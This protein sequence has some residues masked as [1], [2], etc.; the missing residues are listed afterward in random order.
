[1]FP[2]SRPRRNRRTPG[3]RAMLRETVLTPAQLILP[4]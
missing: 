3:L 2:E 4:L 1:M